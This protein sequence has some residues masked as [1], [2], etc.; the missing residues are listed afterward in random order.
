SSS[1]VP[2]SERRRAGHSHGPASSVVARSGPRHRPAASNAQRGA[3]TPITMPGHREREPM[4]QF[5]NTFLAG[6]PGDPDETNRPRQVLGA[7]WSK[8]RPTPV[9]KPRLLA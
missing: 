9:A 3:L 4:L 1:P 2:T 7:A 8:V 6:L 5:E